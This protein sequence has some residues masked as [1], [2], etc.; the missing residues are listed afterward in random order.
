MTD[1]LTSAAAKDDDDNESTT[2]SSTSYSS[3]SSD[4][5]GGAGVGGGLGFNE[6]SF[7]IDDDESELNVTESA[8][9]LGK[10]LLR[11]VEVCMTHIDRS[12]RFN[13]SML[14]SSVHLSSPSSTPLQRDSLTNTTRELH[15]TQ[16]LLANYLVHLV[17]LLQCGN[18]PKMSAA[19]TSLVEIPPQPQTAAGNS[20]CSSSSSNINTTTINEQFNY[21]SSKFAIHVNRMILFKI[22]KANPLLATLWQHFLVL[23]NYQDPEYWLLSLESTSKSHHHNNNEAASAAKSS[24]SA[25]HSLNPESA[26]ATN[27]EETDS[28]ASAKILRSKIRSMSNYRTLRPLSASTKLADIFSPGLDEDLIV[29]RS[30]HTPQ[31][32]LN[33]QLF[34]YLSMTIYCENIA[35]RNQLNNTIGLTMLIINN[36]SELFELASNESIVLDLFS[37]IHRNAAASSLFVHSVATNWRAIA[38]GGVGSGGRRSN[39][40]LQRFVGGSK[41]LYLMHACL[42]SLEG[43][44]LASS[45]HLLNL[46]IDKFFRLPYL[47]LVRYADHIAC[48]RVEMIQSLSLNEL[49]NQFTE[50]Q[51][52]K[53]DKFFTLQFRYYSL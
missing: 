41:K 7:Y 23:C 48:Q 12:L 38:S 29:T 47:S 43:V 14:I 32:T 11:I 26:A 49:A 9:F 4:K 21:D 3:Y 30:S 33:E 36:L 10:F 22:S 6:N 53:L 27:L 13:A 1:P 50:Q 39:R 37:L 46:L 2:N 42:K 8:L 17:Y 16:H 5:R 15:Y 51:L 25:Y 44:H 40:R 28:I 34:K 31:K 45:G 20:S 52:K 18:Y 35:T 19:F 24:S